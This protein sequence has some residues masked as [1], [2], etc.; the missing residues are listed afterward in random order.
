VGSRDVGAPLD[1][2]VPVVAYER[3]TRVFGFQ[4]N[5]VAAE[6]RGESF[7]G[8]LAGTALREVCAR[9]LPRR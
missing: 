9:P 1:E 4:L 5:G 2:V 8:G 7:V 6:S 3:G